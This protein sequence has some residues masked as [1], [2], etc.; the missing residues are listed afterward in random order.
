MAQENRTNETLENAYRKSA[1][2]IAK[3][4]STNVEEGLSKNEVQERRKNMAPM[5]LKSRKKE[6][7]GK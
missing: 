7:S 6:A 5:F 1:E 3:T 4:V 2:E